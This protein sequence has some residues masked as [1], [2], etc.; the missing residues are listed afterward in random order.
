MAENLAA[1]GWGIGQLKA[2][3]GCS[4]AYASELRAGRIRNP[5]IEAW[6]ARLAKAHRA[7]PPPA[8]RRIARKGEADA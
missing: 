8:W 6:L 2:K 1:L 5:V 7:N 3:L 4:Y